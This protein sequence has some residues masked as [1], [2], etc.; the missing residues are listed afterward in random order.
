MGRNAESAVR[1][2]QMITSLKRASK[3][4]EVL[5]GGG[6]QSES[7]KEKAQCL[8]EMGDFISCDFL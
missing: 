5:E 2:E 1:T 7:R 3:V 8:C 4:F 6:A